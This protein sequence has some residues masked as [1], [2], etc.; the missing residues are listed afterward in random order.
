MSSQYFGHS[1]VVAASLYYARRFSR[2]RENKNFFRASICKMA[3]NSETPLYCKFKL[4]LWVGETLV[5]EVL[6]A[7]KRELSTVGYRGSIG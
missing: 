4:L 6:S 2:G 5:L 3:I 7:A 1:L